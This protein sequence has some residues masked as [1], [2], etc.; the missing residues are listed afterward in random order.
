MSGTTGMSMIP[1]TLDIFTLKDHNFQNVEDIRTIMITHLWD[2]NG[3]I[4]LMRGKSMSK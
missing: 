2:S 1:V 3:L 4:N